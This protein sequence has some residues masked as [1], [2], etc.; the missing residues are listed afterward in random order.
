MKGI[1]RSLHLSARRR[2]CPTPH[3]V[4]DYVD[5]AFSQLHRH[6]SSSSSSPLP[7]G[8]SGSAPMAREAEIIVGTSPLRALLLP[9]LLLGSSL[10]ARSLVY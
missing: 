7:R 9:T 8:R 1:A 6:A 10:L 2:A 4:D 3:D 5:R